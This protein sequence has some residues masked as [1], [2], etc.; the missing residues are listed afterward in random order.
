[1]N[2]K[3]RICA[4]HPVYGNVFNYAEFVIGEIA[5][6]QSFDA[7]KNGGSVIFHTREIVKKP[8]FVDY[9]R[10]GYNI[11][12]TA[13]IDFTGSNGHPNMPSSLHFIG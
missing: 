1:M 3:I 2:E 10:S 4:V 12:F 7:A 9:L 13:A 5:I 6:K 11:S 8:S